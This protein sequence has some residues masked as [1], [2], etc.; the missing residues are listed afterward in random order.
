MD[1]FF[2]SLHLFFQK[3]SNSN[4]KRFKELFRTYDHT[5]ERLTTFSVSYIIYALFLLQIGT[6]QYTTTT[7]V[8]TTSTD[9]SVTQS[10]NSSTQLLTTDSGKLISRIKTY[11]KSILMPYKTSLCIR[12]KPW[13][14][15]GVDYKC[16]NW[17]NIGFHWT[18]NFE[19]HRR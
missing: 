8:T 12:Y 7:S 1:I 6:L 2:K 14:N 4:K 5:E 16:P 10:D 19:Q 15:I 11:L 13:R 17:Y 3:N 9:D 18:I